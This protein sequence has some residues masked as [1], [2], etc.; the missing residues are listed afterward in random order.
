A[1]RGRAGRA[2]LPRFVR[3]GGAAGQLRRRRDRARGPLGWARDRCA[4]RDRWAGHAVR[5]PRSAAAPSTVACS[6]GAPPGG[7]VAIWGWLRGGLARVHAA[8]LPGARRR[9][10]W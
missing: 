8:A 4:A 6:A 9:I 1:D 7:D 3:A 5:D 10:A 2:R